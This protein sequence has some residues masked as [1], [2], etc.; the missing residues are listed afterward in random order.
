MSVSKTANQT[1]DNTVNAA[2]GARQV[3]AAPGMTQAAVKA[4][5]ITFYRAAKASALANGA[6][7]AVFIRALQQLGTGGV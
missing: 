4:A 3:A 2:E 6:G 5:E 1:H 7:P